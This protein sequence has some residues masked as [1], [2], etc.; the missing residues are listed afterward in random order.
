VEYTIS[1]PRDLWFAVSEMVQKIGKARQAKRA[2]V[3]VIQ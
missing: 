2:G 3:A 1:R